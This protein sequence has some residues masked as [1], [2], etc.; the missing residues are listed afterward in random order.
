MKE[1]P[2]RLEPVLCETSY[3]RQ[4]GADDVPLK[5]DNSCL[6]MVHAVIAGVF[7]PSGPIACYS[8]GCG[9]ALTK[10]NYMAFWRS[11]VSI[12]CAL[13]LCLF[14]VGCGSSKVTS[15]NFQ[16]IKAGMTEKEVTDVLGSPTETKDKN[17]TWKSG[18]SSI[19]ITY[20]DGKV[21][22]M[23]GKFSN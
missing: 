7:S 11:F 9:P 16:K 20:Q 14:V 13:A 15:E 6:R 3:S 12:T 19:D 18:N 4:R 5:N 17:S 22:G 8:P 23:K 21:A 2:G 10:E 1:S